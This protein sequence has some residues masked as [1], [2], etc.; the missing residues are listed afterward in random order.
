MSRQLKWLAPLVP[1]CPPAR[2][3][4]L[5][6]RGIIR[7]RET[8]SGNT[9]PVGPN[10]QGAGVEKIRCPRPATRFRR[11]PGCLVSS[12][13][14]LLRAQ[15]CPQT[16]G[17]RTSLQGWG[18]PPELPAQ[19]RQ[20]QDREIAFVPDPLG[21]PQESERESRGGAPV[22]GRNARLNARFPGFPLNFRRPGSVAGKT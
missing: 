22:S 11:W 9:A 1:V 14:A 20:R 7:A 5:Q 15:R 10:D 12:N 21:A 3:E 18:T 13:F 19:L 8:T 2:G 16:W 17:G 4:T 6:E